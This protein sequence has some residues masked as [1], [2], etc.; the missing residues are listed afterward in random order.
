ME[1]T[2]LGNTG[3]LIS[4]ISFGNMVNFAPE[5]EEVNTEIIKTCYEAGVNFFD[6]AEMYSKFLKILDMKMERQR[7]N[8]VD[9]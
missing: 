5:D 8:L 9:P 3:L 1:Y 7:N 4:R 6:T 2:R